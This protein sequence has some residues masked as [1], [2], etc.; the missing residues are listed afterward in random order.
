[1]RYI[2][3]VQN[4]NLENNQSKYSPLD[5]EGGLHQWPDHPLPKV[6]HLLGPS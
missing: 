2:D 5:Q 3:L 1:M 6:H 4:F